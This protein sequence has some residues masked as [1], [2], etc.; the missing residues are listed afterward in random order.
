MPFDFISCSYLGAV[1]N[2][3]SAAPAPVWFDVVPTAPEY[4][5]N[6]W[7]STGKE[8]HSNPGTGEDVADRLYAEPGFAVEYRLQNCIL[9]RCAS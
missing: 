3:R 1:R 9:S 4:D 7:N 2:F 6:R 5:L 8:T